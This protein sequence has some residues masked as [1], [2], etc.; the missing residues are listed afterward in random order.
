MTKALVIIDFI[1]DI[2][3]KNG[4][5]PSCA[6]QVSAHHVIDNANI[7]IQWAK[8]NNLPCIF[9]KV[10]FQSSYL[11]LP[12]HS[13]MFGKAQQYRALELGQWGTEFHPNLNVTTDDIVIVKSR[14]N[15]FYNTALDSVLRANAITDVYFCGV[16][17]CWA[18]Q[19]AVRDAH[20]RDY[21]VHIVSDACTSATEQ[22]HQRSLAILARIATLHQAKTL[23]NA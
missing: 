1:N 9:V 4:K 10:G 13:P 6:E 21:C 12:H 14:V 22:D 5:I 20:D 8:N 3:D 18:I 11:E 23:A 15:P 16:S 17:T 19:S 7:A 2:V